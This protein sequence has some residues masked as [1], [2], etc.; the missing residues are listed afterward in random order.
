MRRYWKRVWQTVTV[1]NGNRI[2]EE[3]VSDLLDLVGEELCKGLTVY[4]SYDVK[5]FEPWAKK[6]RASET[7]ICFENF[8]SRICEKLVS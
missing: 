8:F 6:M 5:E 3:V 1:Q 4:K 7:N 2:E